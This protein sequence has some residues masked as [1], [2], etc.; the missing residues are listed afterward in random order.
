[1]KYRNLILCL[2]LFTVSCGRTVEKWSVNIPVKASDVNSVDFDNS[3]F[4]FA[5]VITDDN[6]SAHGRLSVENIL[7]N[8]MLKLTD[9]MTVDID[10]KVQKICINVAELIGT[11][12]LPEIR[13][14]EFDVYADAVS[15]EYINQDGVRIKSVGTI[16][17]GGGT[18]ISVKNAD[19]N[20]KWYDFAET[21]G[22]EYNLEMSGAVHCEFKFLLA[23]TGYCWDESMNDANFLIMRWGSEN[24]S[25]LYIDNIVFF[26][27]NHNS[28]PLA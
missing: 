28:I 19:G 12:R 8:N 3:N 21:Q 26:D 6:A 1:M 7:G 10:G 25:N 5:T 18:V 11:E 22:G 16:C 24:K 20:G 13:S 9:D 14:I 2:F 23:E 17:I 4:S 27:E 15:D